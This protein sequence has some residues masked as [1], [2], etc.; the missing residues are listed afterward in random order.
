MNVFAPLTQ[1]ATPA[2]PNDANITA[3]AAHVVGNASKPVF[4][5]LYGG[6]NVDGSTQSYGN[7]QNLVTLLDHEIVLVALN[8]RLNSFGFLALDELSKTDPR[9]S[10]GNYGILGE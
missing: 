7:I 3:A 5:W 9:G 1:V 10:S 2:A 8:Y 6:G 4:V